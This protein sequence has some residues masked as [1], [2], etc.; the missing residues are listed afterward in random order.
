MHETDAPNPPLAPPSIPPMTDVTLPS[1]KIDDG[2]LPQIE[3]YQILSRLGQGG[4]GTVWRDIQLSTRREVALKLIHDPTGGSAKS[5]ARF[6]R[7]VELTARL[8][9][10]NIARVYDS[11]LH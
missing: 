8:Q 7:E 11:G 10:S 3:G 6:Q 5:L 2:Q 9:H 1:R 4:M